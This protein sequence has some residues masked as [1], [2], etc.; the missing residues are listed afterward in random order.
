[1]ADPLEISQVVLARLGELLRK[2]PP[3]LVTDLYEG[4]AT[5]EVVPK[6]A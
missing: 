4:T 1:M 3:E 2:L 6:A 5:L